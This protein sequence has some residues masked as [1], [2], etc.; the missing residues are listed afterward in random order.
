MIQSDRPAAGR[1]RPASHLAWLVV[2][3]TSAIVSIAASPGRAELPTHLGGAACAQCHPKEAREWTGSHHDLAMQPANESTVKG[4]F[5]DASHTHQGIT[6][7]FFRRGPKFMVHTEGPDGKLSD[8]EVKYVFG[9]EPLQQYMV[10]FDRPAD[11]PKDQIARLQVLRISWDTENK[12]WFYLSPPD[13]DEKL[14]PDDDLHWTGIAQRW[15]TMCAECH[16]TNLQKNF[17]AERRV[18]RTTFTEIDVSCEAC[19]GPGSTHIQLA[20]NK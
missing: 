16:S 3:A 19:H 14:S 10:E 15:N 17:D 7:L 6:T 18:Y 8:F 2:V 9:V 4:N 1:F 11:M 5:N 20:E 12:R 13:V